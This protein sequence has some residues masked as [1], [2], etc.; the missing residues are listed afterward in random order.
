MNDL[1]KKN[2]TWCN[3]DHCSFS[4]VV[5]SSVTVNTSTNPT[6]KNLTLKVPTNLN[7]LNQNRNVKDKHSR[8]KMLILPDVTVTKVPFPQ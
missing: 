1:E 7:I 2:L 6:N 8:I 4:P 5:K 3:C